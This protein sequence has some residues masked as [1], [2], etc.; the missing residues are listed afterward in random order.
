MDIQSIVAK[1]DD[2]NN[3]AMQTL[4][5]SGRA[6]EIFMWDDWQFDAPCWADDNGVATKK[7]QP[8]EAIWTQGKAGYSI[9]TAGEVGASDVIINLRDGNIAVGNPFPV[10]VGIQ[11]IVATGADLNNVAMQT[12]DSSGRADEI[13]M[14]D[15][16]QFDAPCWADDSGVATKT[17]APG[18]GIW[19]QGKAGYTLRFPAP[20][21]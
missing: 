8:G 9:Q 6:D 17:F 12:L 4:D 18:E 21:L 10:S 7:F 13:F 15:D 14:W 11:D 5:S 1:G 19:V 3:V 20:N 16:W 2:L